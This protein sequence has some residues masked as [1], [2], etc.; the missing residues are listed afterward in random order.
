MRTKIPLIVFTILMAAFIL[1]AQA[2]KT[3]PQ[4]EPRPAAAVQSPWPSALVFVRYGSFSPTDEIF[5][6]VYGNGPV[7]GGEFRLHI[8]GRFYISLEGGYFKKTGKLTV[9]QDPTTMTVFPID[10]MVVFHALSGYIMPYVGA[11]GATCKYTEKN[12]IGK[13]NEWGYGFAV[14]GGITAHW[15]SIGIDARVK[16]SSVKVKPLEDDVNLGGLTFSIAAGY[17]F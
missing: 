5:K 2:A 13:V 12:V 11:G 3:A 14:C 1:A 15:R 6:T 7:Y 16:Y 17:I 10:A 8:R 4:T 9:T